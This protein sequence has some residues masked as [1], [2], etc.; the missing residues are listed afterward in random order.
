MRVGLLCARSGVGGIWTPSLDAAAI[1]GAAEVNAEGGVLGHDV[2]LVFGDCGE[3][4]AEAEAAV[5][6]LLEVDCSDA[7]VGAHASHLRDAISQ[8]ISNKAPYIYTPQYEGIACGPSTV[9]IGSTDAEL[10]GP[11]LHWLG[12]EKWRNGFTLWVTI[13]SGRASRRKL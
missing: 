11:A 1:L 4:P 7:I 13:I 9:A 5:D 3:T 2:E 10:L 8:R 12:Q 6:A